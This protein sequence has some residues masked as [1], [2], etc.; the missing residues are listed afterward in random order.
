MQLKVH[1]YGIM[2]GKW[3]AAYLNLI[4]GNRISNKNI[5]T[6][7]FIEKFTH[8]FIKTFYGHFK[9]K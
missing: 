9:I 4:K 7:I 1:F 2:K 8:N 6:Q 5:G 3:V